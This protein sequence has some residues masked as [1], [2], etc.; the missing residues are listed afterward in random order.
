MREDEFNELRIAFLTSYCTFMSL[1]TLSVSRLDY[2]QNNNYN[3]H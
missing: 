2:W 1:H 3:K